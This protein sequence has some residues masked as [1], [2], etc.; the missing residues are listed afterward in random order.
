MLSR[1]LAPLF[2][3]AVLSGAQQP[4][5]PA[6]GQGPQTVPDGGL[7]FVQ[8]SDPQFGFSNSDLD[9]V[10]DT[11]NAEFAVAT[12]NRLKPAFVIVTGDL[13][14]KP[15]DAAQIAEYHRIMAKL[16]RSIPLYSVPG[17]HD[18]ENEPTPATLAAYRKSFGKDY[19]TF[20]AGPLLGIVLN[21]TIIH[22]PKNV[23]DEYDAQDRWLRAEIAKAKSTDAKHVVIFQHH[24]WFLEKADEPDQ[25]F[26]IPRAR[27]DPYL[28]LFRESGIKQL[29]SGH[30]HRSTEA[31]DAGVMTI[32]TG[33]VGRP[34]GG[35][36]GIRIFVVTDAEM[37]SR[38]Y[39]LGE[40]PY[41]IGAPVARGR[42]A[43][44]P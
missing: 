44:T 30:L 32:V 2:A 22:T 20:R 15:G 34:L 1:L 43:G 25:Y 35:Q 26:N 11:A 42:G 37:T 39:G 12:V 14:N 24:P 4:A 21:S 23:Q 8:M 9:F 10:Q 41:K 5:A 27:R 3:V 17:N 6:R 29:V 40:M 7:F 16:D 31:T 19:Y 13:V 28:A 33:P 18:L 36:S 38:Y